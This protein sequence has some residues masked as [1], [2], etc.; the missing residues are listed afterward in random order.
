MKGGADGV[1][2]V[3][4]NGTKIARATGYIGHEGATGQPQYFKFGPYRD[5][6]PFATTVYLDNLARGRSF[7][8]VD[9]A[10]P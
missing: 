5:P 7:A 1:V 3:W 8:E 2:E 10:A 9:P 4:A 6:A